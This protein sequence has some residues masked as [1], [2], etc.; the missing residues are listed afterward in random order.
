MAMGGGIYN[1]SSQYEF[2]K[3]CLEE[4]FVQHLYISQKEVTLVLDT[5]DEP[6]RSA[7]IALIYTLAK[8]YIRADWS[9]IGRNSRAEDVFQHK[10]RVAGAERTAR[11]IIECLANKLGL[12][13]I[14]IPSKVFDV[15]IVDSDY[16]KQMLRH[17]GGGIFL[18]RKAMELSLILKQ[19]NKQEAK[20]YANSKN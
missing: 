17:Q 15:L 5:I 13:S 10:I 6:H 14:A 18:S 3:L 12:Q 2:D 19:R 16:L 9:K 8:I 20:K 11:E 7:I 1:M 4:Q